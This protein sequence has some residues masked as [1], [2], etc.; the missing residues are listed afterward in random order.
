MR[1]AK[2]LSQMV[3]K[4]YLKVIKFGDIVR[5]RDRFKKLYQRSHKT[6]IECHKNVRTIL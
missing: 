6:H 2:V 3:K 5:V 4:M 1:R